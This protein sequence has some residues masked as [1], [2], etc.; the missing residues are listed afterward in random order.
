V[1]YLDWKNFL[2]LVCFLVQGSSQVLI[3]PNRGTFGRITLL[4]VPTS[5]KTTCQ[6]TCHEEYFFHD[7]PSVVTP[8]VFR[9]IFGIRFNFDLNHFAIRFKTRFDLDFRIRF[10]S[11]PSALP[12]HFPFLFLFLFSYLWRTSS[13][14]IPVGSKQFK[15]LI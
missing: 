14:R 1:R 7:C 9:F 13:L 2:V 4:N 8:V 15:I 5:P 11:G 3:T 6:T 12:I 10:N